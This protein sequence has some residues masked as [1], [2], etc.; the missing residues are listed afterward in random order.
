MTSDALS[1]AFRE[2]KRQIAKDIA[3]N[4]MHSFGARPSIRGFMFPSPRDL[5]AHAGV[6][7]AG[8]GQG[9]PAA[10]G[11]G[12]LGSAIK[13]DIG[14]GAGGQEELCLDAAGQVKGKSSGSSLL[15]PGH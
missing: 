10:L 1:R 5:L 8:K 3:M 14:F 13:D 11:F 15:F 12:A 6:V 9:A 4:R 2:P 7:A